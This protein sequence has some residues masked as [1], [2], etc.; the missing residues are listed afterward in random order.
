MATRA[1]FSGSVGDIANAL[2]GLSRTPCIVPDAPKVESRQQRRRRFMKNAEHVRALTVLHSKLCFK[3]STLKLGLI[4]LAAQEPWRGDVKKAQEWAEIEVHKL[5][6]VLR[7]IAQAR[8]KTPGVDWL[9]SF[10]PVQQRPLALPCAFQ[11]AQQRALAPVADGPA[12]E[13]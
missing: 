6:K 10:D 3:K 13:G 5:Q 7:A 11:R 8:L 2:R 1:R 9:K 4:A 12:C